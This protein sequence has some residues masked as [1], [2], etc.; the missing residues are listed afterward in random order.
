MPTKE[1]P[2][3]DESIQDQPVLAELEKKVEE[4]LAEDADTISGGFGKNT[5]GDA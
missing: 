3:Q 1:E 5:G 4:I 2:K